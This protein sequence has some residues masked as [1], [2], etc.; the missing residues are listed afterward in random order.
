MSLVKSL[1]KNP[2]VL[3]SV[4]VLIPLFLIVLSYYLNRLGAF[5]CF[6]D[7]NN[8]MRG[9][10]F[11][12]GREMFSEIF[13][14]HMP[15]MNYISAAVQKITS[16]TSIY[17]LLL[18]HTLFLFIVSVLASILIIIRFR[19]AGLLFVIFYESYNIYLFGDRFLAEGIIV[20]PL[21]YMAGLIWLKF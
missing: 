19:W 3:T 20:Y 5:G 9:Y 6:D 21:A 7:C 13:S 8:F 18:Y 15:L 2:L 11:L 10:F 17:H 16:P 4:L 12:Q 14:G 1:F